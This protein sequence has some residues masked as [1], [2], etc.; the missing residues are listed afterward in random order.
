MTDVASDPIR[1]AIPHREPFLFVSR[2]LEQSTDRIVTEW[3]VSADHD[4]FRGHYPGSPLLPGVL[5]CESS[6]QAGAILCATGDPRD[7]VPGDAVPVLTRIRDARFR[8]MVAPGDTLRFEVSLD[9]RVGPARYMT[10]RVTRDGKNV[11]RVEYVDAPQSAHM[12]TCGPQ[13]VGQQTGVELPVV[14]RRVAHHFGVADAALVPETLGS[15]LAHDFPL[16]F[17]P[18][19]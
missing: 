18:R 9:E 16:L 8:Q 13:I 17:F 3:D 12:G 19:L 15:R 6:V 4:F 7:E 14:A 10:A 2:V 11:G 5:L 1:G